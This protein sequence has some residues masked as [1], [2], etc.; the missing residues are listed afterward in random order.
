MTGSAQDGCSSELK[1]TSALA[2]GRSGRKDIRLPDDNGDPVGER[3][4]RTGEARQ[5]GKVA[6]VSAARGNPAVDVVENKEGCSS[7]MKDS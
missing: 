5:H 1:D 7:D 6:H 2:E 4:T 3:D